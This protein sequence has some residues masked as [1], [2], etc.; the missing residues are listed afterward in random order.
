MLKRI[1]LTAVILTIGSSL[2]ADNS[3]EA[4]FI[5]NDHGKRDP[6]WKLV[7]PGGSIMNFEADLLISDLTLEGI[8]LDPS[9]RNLAIINGNVVKQKDKLGAFVISKIEK[10]R[11]ILLKGQENFILELKREE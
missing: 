1:I 6:F 11:V 5:Y 4:P 3:P 7:T 9:G 10:D 8:I 2:W